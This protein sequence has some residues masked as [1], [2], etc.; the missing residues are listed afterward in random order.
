[1]ISLS[2]SDSPQSGHMMYIFYGSLGVLLWK[3]GTQLLKVPRRWLNP[4]NDLHNLSSQPHIIPDR[5]QPKKTLYIM[6]KN[7]TT[8]TK[9][10]FFDYQEAKYRSLDEEEEKKKK[11]QLSKMSKYKKVVYWF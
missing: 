7:F 2:D 4:E 11:L 5:K 9:G 6:S 10:L 3:C 8:K 1:M